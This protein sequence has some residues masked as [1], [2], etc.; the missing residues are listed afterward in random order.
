MSN[1]IEWEESVKTIRDNLKKELSQGKY[2]VTEIRLSSGF[3][4]GTIRLR[5]VGQEGD[6]WLNGEVEMANNAFNR[7]T[8]KEERRD[9]G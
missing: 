5:I 6:L 9:I 8:I 1:P 4:P 3:D 7:L 2:Y